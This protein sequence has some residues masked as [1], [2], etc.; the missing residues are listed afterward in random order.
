MVKVDDFAQREKLGVTSKSPRWAIAY[1]VELRQASTRVEDIYVQVGKTGV[2]TPV[3]VLQPV[4]VAG[5]TIAPSA[6]STPMRFS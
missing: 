3:A 1:K 4:E 6:S 2:L 5:S